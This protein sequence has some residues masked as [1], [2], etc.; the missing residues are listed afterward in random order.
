M[1]PRPQT[2][3]LI[4]K[5]RSVRQL[6]DGSGTGNLLARIDDEI[7]KLQHNL[8]YLVVLG[9]FK[10]GK[11]TFI[12]SLLGEE[13][14]PVGVVPVTSVV[15]L[16]RFGTATKC[17]VVFADG[18]RTVIQPAA[19][20][21][22][23][24]EQGNPENRRSVRYVEISHPSP[25]LEEGIVLVDTPGIGSLYLHNTDTTQDFIPNVDAAVV[26]L[27][28]DLPITQ[29]EYEFLNEISAHIK[30]LFFVLNKVDLLTPGEQEEALSYTR[31]V[32]CERLKDN[33]SVIPLSGRVALQGTL[34]ADDRLVGQSNLDTFRQAIASFLRDEKEA[35][36]QERSVDRINGF[37]AETRFAVEL[38]LR[39]IT[40]PLADLRARIEEFGNHIRLLNADRESFRYLLEGRVGSLNKWIEGEIELFSSE[41]T[42]QLST[43]LSSWAQDHAALPL[44]DFQEQIREYFGAELIRDF[45]AWRAA[46]DKT[47]MD[48][49]EA[50]IATFV[51]KTNEFIQRVLQLS[52][53]MFQMQLQPF[54]RVRAM[55]W[56]NSF[57]YKVQ[58]DPLFFD[59][60]AMTFGAVL[61]PGKTAQRQV[62]RR[63][64]ADVP[65]AVS[66]H[67]GRL[68]YEYDYSIQESYR[69]FQADLNEKIDSIIR[70]IETTLHDAVTMKTTKE[71]ALAPHAKV[72]QERLGQL[73]GLRASVEVAS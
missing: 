30:K 23:V 10:R 70:Q 17:E 24:T 33:V 58:D 53:D 65:T 19:L 48:K 66:R 5:L 64:L 6:V 28:A 41:E 16:V 62:L 59:F 57:Y 39:A 8:F 45:D 69:K 49:Y 32:L 3:E 31:N 67:C 12:N 18:H 44:R 42:R 46:N 68:R 50:I 61:L 27:S 43:R 4:S 63:V 56:K 35:V 14:L 73:S 26:V 37:I 9:Q 71:S 60:D 1:T 55:E 47:I 7:Q 2:M 36:L 21:D 20:R 40:T 72:L 11:T 13:L 29:T 22:Y 54:E 51:E 15:T 25:F 52:A 38:E 34:Q